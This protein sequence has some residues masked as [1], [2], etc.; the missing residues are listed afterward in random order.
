MSK[1]T[2]DVESLLIEIGA[3]VALQMMHSSWLSSI[4][5]DINNDDTVN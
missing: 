5:V 3:V 2:T 1:R 4:N